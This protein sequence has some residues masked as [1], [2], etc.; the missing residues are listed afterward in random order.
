MPV[1]PTSLQTKRKLIETS[2]EVEMAAK[3][4]VGS[5]DVG[6]LMNVLKSTMNNLLEEKLENLPTKKDI[7]EVKEGIAST[8]AELMELRE[9]NKKL[10][11]EIEALKNTQKEYGETIKWLEHQVKNN[12]LLFKG[13][14]YEKS[15]IESARKV[16]SNMLKIN[17][18]ITSARTIS[19]PN[20]NCTVIVEFDSESTVSY[21][22][23]ATK[24]LAGSK[25][26]ICRDLNPKRQRNKITMLLI[27]KLILK[28]SKK[29]RIMVRDDKMK[30]NDKWFTWNARNELVCGREKAETV[31]RELY[32][33]E[34][35]TDSLHEIMENA[36]SKN[37]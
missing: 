30:I 4:P 15:A 7:D 23:G 11:E 3:K 32:G 18:Q 13:I 27:K 25:I 33:E 10:K 24:N 17:P 28:D 8:R 36:N 22:L 6:E 37:L 20:E 5:M 29:H 12:K 31:L 9:E 2:P 14:P 19:K 21:V 34:L 26:S 1:N 16:C 35:K